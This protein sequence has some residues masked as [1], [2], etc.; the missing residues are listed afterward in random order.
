VRS[1]GIRQRALPC[2]SGRSAYRDLYKRPILVERACP[3][4]RSNEEA[5]NALPAS[6]RR[7]LGSSVK[8]EWAMARPWLRREMKGEAANAPRSVERCTHLNRLDSGSVQALFESVK[9]LSICCSELGFT[10]M[11]QWRARSE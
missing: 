11:S 6:I 1:V 4:R 2:N 8:R 3:T 7:Q 9:V 5:L 10:L